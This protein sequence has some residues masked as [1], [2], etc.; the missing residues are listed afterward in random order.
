MAALRAFLDKNTP[1]GKP[2]EGDYAEL[3][4]ENDPNSDVILRRKDGTPRVQMAQ[5]I[6]EALR[7]EG[8]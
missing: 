3:A 1:G 4:D 8:L 5:E 2:Q 7:A 6:W